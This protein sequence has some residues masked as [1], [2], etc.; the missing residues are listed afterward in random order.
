MKW[1]Q[2][3]T[4]PQFSALVYSHQAAFFRLG[5]I[6]TKLFRLAVDCILPPSRIFPAWYVFPPPRRVL[7]TTKAGF[8]AAYGILY[9]A[10][11]FCAHHQ[12]AMP[13]TKRAPLDKLSKA[14]SAVRPNRWPNIFAT[15]GSERSVAH[16]ERRSRV[17]RYVRRVAM[18]AGLCMRI[19]EGNPLTVSRDG[20]WYPADLE[21]W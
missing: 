21:R 2:I 9:T 10:T 19:R 6:P 12:A 14:S 4:K 5:V 13:Q 1:C 20:E 16:D 7:C 8:Y 3:L 18:L 17:V 11:S 15:E